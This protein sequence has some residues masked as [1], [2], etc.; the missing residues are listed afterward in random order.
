MKYIIINADDFGLSDNINTGIA[1]CMRE[2]IVK[3]VESNADCKSRKP[4]VITCVL[5]GRLQKF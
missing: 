1:R 4:L 5:P 2:G 3:E